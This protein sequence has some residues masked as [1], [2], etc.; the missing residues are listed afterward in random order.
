MAQSD[1]AKIPADI[2]KMT[3]EEALESLEEI[4]DRLPLIRSE[5]VGPGTIV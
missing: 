3:F 1:P 5:S 4:V 2:A